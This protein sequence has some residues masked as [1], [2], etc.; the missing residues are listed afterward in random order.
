M[1]SVST[2][3]TEI[4][5]MMDLLKNTG[6][7]RTR[8][9]PESLQKIAMS[10]ADPRNYEF[11]GPANKGNRFVR[12]CDSTEDELDDVEDRVAAFEKSVM[13]KPRSGHAPD[14]LPDHAERY[15]VE[16]MFLARNQD[17]LDLVVGET[18]YRTFVVFE[19]VFLNV[20]VFERFLK[21]YF[22]NLFFRNGSTSSNYVL[23]VLS[24]GEDGWYTGSKQ[25]GI[26]GS[27]P[28]HHVETF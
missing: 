12:N 5:D 4:D 3:N 8:D 14:W 10:A 19:L 15:R 23:H 6:I 2:L 18:V 22:V 28:G 27:F 16:Q 17:E 7:Q 1:N 26:I 20:C 21:E 11:R 13:S 24:K 25:N 9:T